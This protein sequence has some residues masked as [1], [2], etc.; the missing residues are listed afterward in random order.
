MIKYTIALLFSIGVINAQDTMNE[1]TSEVEVGDV[2][3][4]GK[5]ETN[6]YKHINFPRPNFIIKRGGRVNYKSVEGNKVI[7]TSIKEKKNGTT[8]IKI[9]RKDGGRFFGSHT[10]VGA[11]FGEALLSGELQ[12]R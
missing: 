5:P 12:T 10:T 3:E 6:N 11:N 8:Q 4:I 2:F 9:K 7:V 1:V